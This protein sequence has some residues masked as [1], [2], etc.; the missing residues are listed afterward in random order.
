M[1]FLW[2]GPDW[3]GLV[4]WSTGL[5]QVREKT[6]QAAPILSVPEEADRRKQQC[7]DC[8]VNLTLN[9]ILICVSGQSRILIFTQIGSSEHPNY[10]DNLTRRNF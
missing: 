1:Q 5:V 4:Q 8:Q 10:P 6:V 2:I 9:C 3:L 7:S